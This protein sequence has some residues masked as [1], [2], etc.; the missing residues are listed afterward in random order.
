VKDIIMPHE[1]QKTLL[2]NWH[3]S[4]G[5]NMGIFSGYDMPLWYSTGVKEEHLTVLT[6]AG[7]FDTSH[8]DGVMVHGPDALVFLNWMFTKDLTQCLGRKTTPLVPGRCAYGAFLN[9][10]GH[11]VDDS[12]IFQLT[13]DKYMLYVN[14]SMGD[15]ITTHLKAHRQDRD[16][17]IHNNT[18]KIGKIDLQGP[19]AG[20][21]LKKV[22]KDPDKVLGDMIYF[23]FKGYFDTDIDI[24]EPV[25]IHD[26]TPVLISRTGY[27][28][29]FGFEIFML[30]EKLVSSWETILDAGKTF[31]VIPCGLAARDSLR[32][33]AV[34]PLSHQDIGAWPYIN[35]PW[36]FSLPFDDEQKHFTKKFLGDNALLN[37]K[38]PEYTYPFAG[39]DL[40]KVSGG[41]AVFEEAKE[42]PV[43][44]VLTC[45]TDMGIGRHENRIYSIASPGLPDNF[46][47]KGLSC[48]FI[49]VGKKLTAGQI[50]E[51]RDRRH[52]KVEVVEDI[53]P[54]RTAHKPMKQ[55][56]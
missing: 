5:A 12:I 28:G 34:L 56:L 21:V 35:H 4:H 13:R 40:R 6:R 42:M 16:V 15:T 30:P 20:K 32:A 54:D 47:P 19:L 49:K 53:R 51:L 8:M 29:E 24:N 37:L 10:N 27:T 18:G 3:R 26:G 17:Q 41:A 11:V 39:F 45:V 7:L 33:G 46:E 38:N 1:S 2:N 25:Y 52:I 22:I 48:G 36:R 23:K 50:V 43:G 44:T 31:G 9:A 14:A 55:M